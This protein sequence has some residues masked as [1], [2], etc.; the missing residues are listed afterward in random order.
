MTWC[1]LDRQEL[2][3]R[4]WRAGSQSAPTKPGTA[5]YSPPPVNGSIGWLR[6]ITEAPCKPNW[7]A[8]PATPLLVV[9]EVG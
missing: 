3:R 8:W 7:S 4:A 2:A 5:A 1:S 9:D 6:P